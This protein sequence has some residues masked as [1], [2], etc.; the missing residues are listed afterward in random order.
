MASD[1]EIEASINAATGNL[2]GAQPIASID[3]YRN[4]LK[5]EVVNAIAASKM[6]EAKLAIMTLIDRLPLT[7]RIDFTADLADFYA[8]L[9][10]RPNDE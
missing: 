1:T 9:D 10:P 7:D 3:K 2:P 6:A 4:N 5:T 8:E